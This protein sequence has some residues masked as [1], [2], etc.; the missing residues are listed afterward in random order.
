[1]R[2]NPVATLPADYI[3]QAPK[4]TDCT[5]R[6]Y[7][8][9]GSQPLRYCFTRSRSADRN[10]HCSPSLPLTSVSISIKLDTSFS[11]MFALCSPILKKMFWQWFIMHV[12]S[13][14]TV[15]VKWGWVHTC[16]VTAYRNAVTLQETD[17]IRSYELNFHSVPHGVTVSWERYT[18]AFPVCYGSS[19]WWWRV[20][21]PVHTCSGRNHTI[22]LMRRPK[23]DSTPNKPVT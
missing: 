7:S 3:H 8:A 2:W 5:R 23:T 21:L 10:T 11:N 4:L 19:G 17:M 1:M 15:S 16:N 13:S 6:L 9:A 20:T 14:S 18:L 12:C 22:P